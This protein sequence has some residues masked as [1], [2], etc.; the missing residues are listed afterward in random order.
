MKIQQIERIAKIAWERVRAYNLHVQREFPLMFR[1]FNWPEWDSPDCFQQCEMIREVDRL[2]MGFELV[3]WKRHN[4]VIQKRMRDG[5][6]LGPVR[7]DEAGLD[8][9]LMFWDGLPDVIRMWLS[10]KD[11]LL[12][13]TWAKR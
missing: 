13:D 11:A 3:G 7:D 4:R 10:G 12:L 9:Y 2:D 8:P 6:R 5:F 1:S